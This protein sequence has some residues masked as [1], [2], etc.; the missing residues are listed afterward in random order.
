MYTTAIFSTVKV[1]GN[2]DFELHFNNNVRKGKKM[3]WAKRTI[4][5]IETVSG[6]HNAR[7]AVVN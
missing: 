1:V 3:S 6:I 4:P 7:R 5:K 2:K